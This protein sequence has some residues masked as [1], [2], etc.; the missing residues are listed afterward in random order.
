MK[1]QRHE[2]TISQK[3]KRN[4]K[5]YKTLDKKKQEYVRKV[6]MMK[7]NEAIV[8]ITPVKQIKRKLRLREKLL[9][10]IKATGELSSIRGARYKGR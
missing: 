7:I 6:N 9:A 1:K 3:Q 5:T 8:S 4:S 2:S 10:I